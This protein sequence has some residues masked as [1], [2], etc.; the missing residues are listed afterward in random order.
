MKIT[1][2][3]YEAYALD[4]MEGALPS[5]DLR[6]F[7]DFLDEN[8]DIKEEVTG[9]SIVTLEADPSLVFEGKSSLYQKDKTAVIIPMWTKFRSVAAIT[10]ILVA[11]TVLFFALDKNDGRETLPVTEITNRELG[12][13]ND[14]SEL[15][16]PPEESEKLNSQ[17]QTDTNNLAASENTS[18]GS[19]HEVQIRGRG[20]SIDHIESTKATSVSRKSHIVEPEP[21]GRQIA[22]EKMTD[23]NNSEQ[24]EPE[25]F[26][27]K[28]A[29][30]ESLPEL[31]KVEW[32][33]TAK[34]DISKKR[35]LAIKENSNQTEIEI[36]IP[37]EFL[38]ETWSDVSLAQFKEK[39]IPEFLRTK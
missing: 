15:H 32:V 14:N 26:R 3:N 38:S 28:L 27:E 29:S 34:V 19:P 24:T 8:P 31:P 35:L 6:S 16:N 23:T 12:T 10:V 33:A 30:I 22:V 17:S 37:G 20:E 7:E 21:M 13:E 5:S 4:Y 1:R 18:T 11:A 9:F 2:D 25:I 36:H 39:L